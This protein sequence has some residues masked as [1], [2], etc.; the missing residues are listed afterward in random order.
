M[1]GQLDGRNREA[2]VRAYFVQNRNQIERVARNLIESGN[3]EVAGDLG[4][5]V[6]ILQL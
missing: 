1:D 5:F 6:R 2:S 3:I 4:E